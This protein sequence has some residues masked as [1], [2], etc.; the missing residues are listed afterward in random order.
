[1]A[2]LS[3]ALVAV[4]LVALVC[5]PVVSAASSRRSL[6]QITAHSKTKSK[7]KGG[8]GAPGE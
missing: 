5:T 1:M 4:C 8:S 3:S 7:G 6:S 2:R